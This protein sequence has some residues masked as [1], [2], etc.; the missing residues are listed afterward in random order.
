MGGLWSLAKDHCYCVVFICVVYIQ[1]T[2]QSHVEIVK[3]SCH[4]LHLGLCHLC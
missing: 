1:W 3:L 2:Q 4:D